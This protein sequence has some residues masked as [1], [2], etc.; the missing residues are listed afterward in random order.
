MIVAFAELNT[1]C[2]SVPLGT[3][4]SDL[5][6]PGTLPATMLLPGGDVATP[7]EPAEETEIEVAVSWQSVP[8]YDLE[9]PGEYVFTAVVEGECDVA[10]E[11]PTV[12]VTVEPP[13][14]EV[15]VPENV[16]VQPMADFTVST[17]EALFDAIL[18]D[19][20]PVA[21]TVTSSIEM[22]E[23]ITIPEDK[24]VSITGSTGN[25]ILTRGKTGILFKVANGSTLTLED[26]V[27]DGNKDVFSNGGGSLVFVYGGTFNMDDGA[28]LQNNTNSS[29]NGGGV[30]VDSGEFI[31]NGGEITNNN[32]N[33]PLDVGGGVYVG[34]G[35]FTLN[36]GKIK[37]NGSEDNGGGV[38][39]GAGKFSMTGGE[40]SGNT[41]KDDGGG[42]YVESGTFNM[43]GSVISGNTVEEYGGGVYVGSGTFTMSDGVISGNTAVLD[44]GGVCLG[45]GKFTMTDG[46]ITGNMAKGTYGGGVDFYGG[47]VTVGG[48]AVISGNTLNEADNNLH[49]ENDEL[50]VTLATEPDAPKAGMSVGI[51][52]END[53][54]EFVQSGA[55]ADYVQHFFADD[56]T[57]EVN[58]VEGG[59]LQLATKTLGLPVRPALPSAVVNPNGTASLSWNPVSGAT[60]YNVTVKEGTVPVSVTYDEF[61]PTDNARTVIDGLNNGTTYT[62]EV[63]A[64]NNQGESAAAVSSAF[65]P[66]LNAV[67]GLIGQER[68]GS[69]RL[70]WT[71]VSD[72]TGY[73]VERKEVVAD[74]DTYITL[75]ADV[76][77]GGNPVIYEDYGEP[78]S[79]IYRVI[80]Y[81]YAGDSERIPATTNVNILASIYSVTYHLNG[82]EQQDG[83]WDS[84]TSGTE[85]S[86]P[87]APTR[88]GFIFDG[89]YDNVELTGDAV[90]KIAVGETGNKEFWAKWTAKTYGITLDPET[91]KTFDSAV[92]GYEAQT[93]HS[94]TVRNMGNQFTSA[95]TVALTGAGMGS[96]TL[97]TTTIDSI[98]VSGNDSFT[99]TPNTGLD[100]G[101]YTATV[102]V[103][104]SG[105]GISES[106]NVSFTVTKADQA[107]PVDLVAVN[108]GN[109]QSN[110]KITGLNASKSYE[111]KLTSA[112]D[113]T[114]VSASATEIIGLAAGNYH[115]RIA[116]DDNHNPGA[117]ANITVGENAAPQSISITAQPA[118]SGG[119]LTEGEIDSGDTLT[120]T[121]Q[122]HNGTG[123]LAY[124]WY[125]NDTNNTDTSTPISSGTGA[126]L[127][128]PTGLSAGTHYFYAVVSK[129]G[130]AGVTPVTSNIVAITVAAA[131]S[132]NRVPTATPTTRTGNVPAD[133][134]YNS[135]S[136]ISWF[137]DEDGDTLTYDVTGG[138]GTLTKT[139][140]AS[141]GF[142]YAPSESEAGSTVTLTVTATDGKST[143]T[144][145]TLTLTVSAVQPE[146][147]LTA[148][149][150][151]NPPSK[152]VYTVGENFSSAGMVVTAYYSDNTSAAIT[153]YTVSPS[154]A[155]ATSDTSVTISYTEDGVTKTT[156]QDITM[157]AAVVPTYTITFNPN[158][159]MVSP[160]S[161]QTGADGKLVSLPT[162]TRSGHNFSGWFTAITGGTQVTT[163]TVFLASAT[164]YARWISVPT[165]DPTY[166][167][168]DP[169]HIKYPV[170]THP[171]TW[172]W[173][174]KGNA[175]GK[176][177][178]PF[179]K[180][181][182]VLKDGI[183]VD[184]IHYTVT[185]GS[186]IITF[187]ESY[188]NTLALSAHTLRVEFT[189]GHADLTLFVN[190]EN[191]TDVP[192]T[193]DS[194]NMTGWLIT[195]ILSTAG[196]AF[197][198]A[199]RR[200]RKMKGKW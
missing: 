193:G 2:V 195:L 33:D 29:D 93:A 136:L 145:V 84:Y 148:I 39:V 120:V 49:L 28:V 113:Y 13:T 60:G 197:V 57:L 123:T 146:K 194:N 104:N 177:D 142:T 184:P 153:G 160:A 185:E 41:A 72:A 173:G 167:P 11:L 19:V 196:V 183:V 191:V 94:V 176:I 179:S 105:N 61:N 24:E 135:G 157:N 112:S 66:S 37:N 15:V 115:V 166:N 59:K 156:T 92:Y 35:E 26:I 32:A 139:D 75:K 45:G 42:V 101:T 51:T 31:M 27:L 52:L 70:E 23:L 147:N 87:T 73:R 126:T 129:Q 152:I 76:V 130:D 64:V 55:T 125:Q 181:V 187:K 46:E 172:I 22:T 68:E 178:A 111:Y 43:T 159:G 163:D 199:W 25:E 58:F 67:Y 38:S 96:F 143:P 182:R 170:I 44:G 36:D 79:Y 134:T 122:L 128:L 88:D 56:E 100:A 151:T 158:G 20:T 131:Q 127:E 8:E 65:T 17:F 9:T 90:T 77:P 1:E 144:S 161:M 71:P 16:P 50:H 5:G 165:D 34:Y 124:Q 91:N 81:N 10:T 63:T 12:T 30:Y 140:I 98:A 108:A 114:I 138:S 62:F 110:G 82:G 121:A 149:A 168:T 109:G 47:A 150:V 137:N 175:S 102:T 54:S 174:G 95:L 192:K 132:E 48:S 18:S 83:A 40:I 171:G 119:N 162:P 107:A 180:F 78:G 198:L 116:G 190:L 21:I 186:T 200:W 80:P 169:S 188:L 14:V 133:G 3:E 97:S 74:D 89:W 103:S 189:D 117:N 141:T 6:L 53:S 86:L 155:L 99:V 4:E 85:F 154:G 69:V 164:V 7:S 106:F 118:W